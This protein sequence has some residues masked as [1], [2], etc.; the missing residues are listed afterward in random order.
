LGEISSV[1]RGSSTTCAAPIGAHGIIDGGK[2]KEPCSRC[3]G[4]VATM[5][6]PY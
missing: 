1:P 5:S 2:E 3:G 4:E 6:N